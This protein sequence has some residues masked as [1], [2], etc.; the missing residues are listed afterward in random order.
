V[1]GEIIKLLRIEA[2][3]FLRIQPRTQKLCRAGGSLSG[4][5]P[6]RKGQNQDGLTERW[7]SLDD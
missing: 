6:A 2:G 7:Q 4:I 3:K 1:L 5:I